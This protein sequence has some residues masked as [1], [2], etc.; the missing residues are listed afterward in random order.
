MK[1]DMQIQG[2]AYTCTEG[3]AVGESARQNQHAKI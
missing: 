1:V 3:I 2:L